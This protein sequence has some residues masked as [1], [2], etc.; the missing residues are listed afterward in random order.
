MLLFLTINIEYEIDSNYVHI[1]QK[2]T[3]V[4]TKDILFTSPSCF[5]LLGE[6]MQRISF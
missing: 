2:K 4:T 1:L 6:G 5:Q 3:F